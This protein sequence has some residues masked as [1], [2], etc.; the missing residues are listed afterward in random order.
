[1]ETFA[2]TWKDY[3]NVATGLFEGLFNDTDF[4]DVTL[5]CADNKQTKSHKAILS[6]CSS[7]FKEILSANVHQ[8]PLIYL[9]GIYSDNLSKIMEFVYKGKTEVDQENLEAFLDAA[10]DLKIKGLVDEVIEVVDDIEEENVETGI[11]NAKTGMKNAKTGIES[12]KEEIKE[13]PEQS[14][15]VHS[16]DPD[17]MNTGMEQIERR[18]HDMAFM[19]NR[20]NGNYKNSTVLKRHLLSVHEGIKQNCM[21]CAKEFSTVDSLKRHTKSS[22]DGIK[23]Q[24]KECGNSFTATAALKRHKDMKHTK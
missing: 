7:L 4:T 21:E 17:E 24:C 15:L 14:D 3:Q 23:Y 8:H 20:C 19:C 9:K 18:D 16:V 6:S 10:R 22:H 1:M 12:A 11:E 2:L 5:V 13:D